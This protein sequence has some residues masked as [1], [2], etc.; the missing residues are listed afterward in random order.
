LRCVAAALSTCA[1]VV[2][3]LRA[4]TALVWRIW[5]GRK[6]TRYV[7]GQAPLCGSPALQ[8]EVLER[9]RDELRMREHAAQRD[10]SDLQDRIRHQEAEHRCGAA[11]ASVVRSAVCVLM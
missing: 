6:S 3:V 4:W 1:D 7:C 8:L 9:E 10:L 5:N 11:L 2:V